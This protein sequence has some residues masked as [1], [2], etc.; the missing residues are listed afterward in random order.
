MKNLEQV[1]EDLADDGETY[2]LELLD[3]MINQANEQLIKVTEIAPYV[4]GDSMLQDSLMHIHI[5]TYLSGMRMRSKVPDQFKSEA[6]SDI[7][8]LASYLNLELKKIA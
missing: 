1:R 4:K 2:V 3:I 6:D 8:K 7:K 5:A